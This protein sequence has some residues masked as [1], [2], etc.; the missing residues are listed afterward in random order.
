MW[1]CGGLGHFSE[2]FSYLYFHQGLICNLP[3]TALMYATS[4]TLGISENGRFGYVTM[5]KAGY[6]TQITCFVY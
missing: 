5:P 1:I 2:C 4:L 6:D 3:M